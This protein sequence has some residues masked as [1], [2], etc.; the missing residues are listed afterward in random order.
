MYFFNPLVYKRLFPTA[1]LPLSSRLSLVATITTVYYLWMGLEAKKPR[2][3]HEI[4]NFKK[5]RTGAGDVWMDKLQTIDRSANI[6]FFK[7]YQIDLGSSY[8]PQ[9]S[10][11]NIM[12]C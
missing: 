12:I 7:V 2:L 10:I 1:F 11:N 6:S 8:T 3:S 5:S 4:L 9:F